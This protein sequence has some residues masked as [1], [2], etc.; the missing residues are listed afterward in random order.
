MRP[1]LGFYASDWLGPQEVPPH[2]RVS[3][4]W[5]A[6]WVTFLFLQ[7]VGWAGWLGLS[8]TIGSPVYICIYIYIYMLSWKRT[9]CYW[10]EMRPGGMT[11]VKQQGMQVLGVDLSPSV[12][13][14]D[15]FLE[16]FLFMLNTCLSLS[17]S[18]PSAWPRI[19]VGQL[20]PGVGKYKV[21][22]GREL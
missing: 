10:N 12:S 2:V 11:I 20:R 14:K 4:R 1:A 16:P 7:K 5:M 8:I 22:L 3:T 15:R 18:G 21:H 19:W 9:M 17:W 6:E 13:I